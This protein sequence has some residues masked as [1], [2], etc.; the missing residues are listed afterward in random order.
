[1]K[2]V[3]EKSLRNFCFW[4]GAKDN[5]AEL[6]LEQLD[7]LEDELEQI[8]SEG[9]LT[10]TQINDIMWFDFEWVK[11]ILGIQEEEDEEEE[12]ED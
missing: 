9:E 8:Y 2:Y 11:E 7:Q 4:S 3:V 12:D 6:T 1:M 10:D 5:A